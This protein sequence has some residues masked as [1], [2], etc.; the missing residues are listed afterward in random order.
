MKYYQEM[1]GTNGESGMH[2]G[3]ESA[4][5]ES[6]SLVVSARNKVREPRKEAEKESEMAMVETEV[7]G[8]GL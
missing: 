3:N 8:M 6:Y 5:R 4:N 2:Q 7:K 1:S